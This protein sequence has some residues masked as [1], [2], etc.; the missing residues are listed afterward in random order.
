MKPDDFHFVCEGCQGTF[1]VDNGY[2]PQ[3][4]SVAP[5]DE[6]AAWY[7]GKC[8][9][10]LPTIRSKRNPNNPYGPDE[11]NRGPLGSVRRGD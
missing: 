9:R 8:Y 4:Q 5:W 7:C 6:N 2:C 1:L 11:D 10:E 3:P